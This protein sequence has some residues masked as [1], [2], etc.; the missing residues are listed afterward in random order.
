MDKAIILSAGEQWG[1]VDFPHDVERAR[2]LVA[3]WEEARKAA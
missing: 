3:G 2:A 1:E